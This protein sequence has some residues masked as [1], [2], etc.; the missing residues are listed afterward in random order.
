[1]DRAEYGAAE[2]GALDACAAQF[3]LMIENGRLTRRAVEQEKLRRDLA[4]AAEVQKRLFPIGR[5]T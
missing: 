4:I 3:A 5:P 2:K 1:V